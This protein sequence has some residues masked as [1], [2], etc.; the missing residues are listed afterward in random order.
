[1]T[2]ICVLSID[3]TLGRID[4]STLSDQAM[5]E[6]LIA[7]LSLEIKERYQ[8]ENGLY[9]EVCEWEEIYCNGEKRVTHV[10]ID[11]QDNTVG[12]VNLEYIPRSVTN[13]DFVQNTSTGLLITE[14]LRETL[15]VL[16]IEE[17][18]LAGNVDFLRFPPNLV[19]IVLTGNKFEGSCILTKLPSSLKM[20]DVCCNNFRGEVT[21]DELPQTL[22]NIDLSHNNFSGRI[23]FDKL[24]ERLGGVHISDINFSGN[25]EILNPSKNLL[26]INAEFNDFTGTA[27][28]HSSL[29]KCNMRQR[30][31]ISENLLSRVLD[32]NG[33]RH[34]LEKQFL[35]EQRKQRARAPSRCRC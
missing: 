1:M 18:H 16:N 20:L 15:K 35:K 7:G 22:C 13:F 21:L 4:V 6:T 32:E 11:D 19:D 33:S 27:R 14:S 26:L 3:P 17:T 8:D 2:S 24:P 5:M 28:V 31:D 10:F 12:V 34:H 25:F 9:L 30:F 29:G 23:S